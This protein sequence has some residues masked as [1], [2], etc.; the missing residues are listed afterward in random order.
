[1]AAPSAPPPASDTILPGPPIPAI[2]RLEVMS[3]DDWEQ[4]VLEWAD[5][6][7]DHYESVELHG[8]AQDLGCDIVVYLRNLAAV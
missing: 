7:R 5:W 3:A 6:L 1:M 2:K 4:F 8:G